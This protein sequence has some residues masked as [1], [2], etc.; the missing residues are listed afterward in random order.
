MTDLKHVDSNGRPHFI[1]DRTIPF[2]GEAV[3][4]VLQFDELHARVLRAPG[5]AATLLDRGD[6]CVHLYESKSEVAQA[7]HLVVE[8]V[9]SAQLFSSV[10]Q[11]SAQAGGAP[12]IGTRD[13]R[14][15]SWLQF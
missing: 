2:I 13:D 6:A 3:L 9:A 11:R 5:N 10:C 4:D 8:Q 1:V 14:I 15:W 7:G 12:Q